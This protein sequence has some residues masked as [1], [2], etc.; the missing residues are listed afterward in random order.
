MSVR[1]LFRCECGAGFRE[2]RAFARHV[3]G[4]PAATG[5]QAAALKQAAAATAPRA[6]V[7]RCLPEDWQGDLDQPSLPIPGVPA[8]VIRGGAR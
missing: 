3:Q 8:V 7:R 5:G 2:R 4:C 1:Y 6:R